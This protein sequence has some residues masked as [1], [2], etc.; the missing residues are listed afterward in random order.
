ML[1]LF[2]EKPLISRKHF[3]FLFAI[4][5]ACMFTVLSF[6]QTNYAGVQF[7]YGSTDELLIHPINLTDSVRVLCWIMTTPAN[8]ET[9][10]LHV[11]QTWGRRCNKLLLMSSTDDA[12]LG[13]IALAGVGE[14]RQ[15]LWNKTREAFRY[16]YEQHLNEYDW[17]LKADDDT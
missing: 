5:I 11:K 6:L 2:T 9:K 3:A 4:V 1:H 17:F 10:A 8:H 14:G 13:T 12:K 16:V 7:R 15:S